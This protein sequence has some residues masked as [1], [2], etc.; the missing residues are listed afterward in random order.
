MKFFVR[1]ILGRSLTPA[2]YRSRHMTAAKTLLKTMKYDYN[3]VVGALYSLRDKEAS[4]F[5]YESPA[6]LPDRLEGMEI[7][8]RWGE[9]PLI[10]RWLTPPPPPPVYS[11]DYDKWVQSWG[12]RAIARKVWDGL[13]LHQDP[14]VVEVWLRPAIGAARFEESLRIWQTLQVTWPQSV[15]SYNISPATQES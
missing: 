2:D 3:D 10:E 12:K 7:L 15:P 1:E 5:G 11:C 8:Y 6:Q 4:H 14:R 13:Y 9:P